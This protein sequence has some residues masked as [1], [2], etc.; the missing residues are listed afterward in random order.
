[1]NVFFGSPCILIL[2]HFCKIP[3]VFI[4]CV[5]WSRKRD[6]LQVGWDTMKK[7]LFWTHWTQQQQS[8]RNSFDKNVFFKQQTDTKTQKMRKSKKGCCFV[9]FLAGK[10][11]REIKQ[12]EKGKVR[13]IGVLTQESWHKKKKG[14]I[15]ALKCIEESLD[16]DCKGGGGV[17][18]KGGVKVEKKTQ[19]E[20]LKN[21]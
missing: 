3:R 9:F 19:K 13:V 10:L 7:I 8:T 21:R 20:T 5:I 1:M 17:V 11:E 16:T 12:N 14:E 4:G 2:R 15:N 18:V 6:W